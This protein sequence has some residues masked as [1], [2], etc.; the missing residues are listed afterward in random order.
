MQAGSEVPGDSKPIPKPSVGTVAGFRSLR[1]V[2]SHEESYKY[3]ER[4]S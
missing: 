1:A 4:N 3:A 2:V